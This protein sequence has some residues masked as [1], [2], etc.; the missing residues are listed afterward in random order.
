MK[1][2][3]LKHLAIMLS[4]EK[5]VSKATYDFILKSLSRKN[6]KTFLY[7][8]RDSL[9]KKRAYVTTASGLSI[10]SLNN[11]KILFKGKEI[12]TNTDD[13]IGAGIRIQQGDSIIDYTFKRYINDTIEQLK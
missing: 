12:I 10:K 1:K 3:S 7:F 6:L 11:L 8:Y 13:S 2:N 9:Q 4:R 5:T